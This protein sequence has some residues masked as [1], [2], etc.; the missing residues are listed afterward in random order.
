MLKHI[1]TKMLLFIIPVVIITVMT[2]YII[3]ITLGQNVINNEVSDKMIVLDR[4]KTTEIDKLINEM[5]SITVSLVATVSKTYDEIEFDEYETI[6]SSI[7]ETSPDV[8]GVAIVLEPYTLGDD[9]PYSATYAQLDDNGNIHS[10]TD[11]SEG[12]YSFYESEYYALSQESDQISFTKPYKDKSTGYSIMVSSMPINDE[13]GDY[14]GCVV[15]KVKLSDISLMLNEYT[16]DVNKL[17]IIDEDGRFI[18]HN[19]ISKVEDEISIYDL[20][21]QSLD[22]E[23]INDMFNDSKGT[24]DFYDETTHYRAYYSTIDRFNWKL[25]YVVEYETLQSNITSSTPFFILMAILTIFV[26]SALII[27]LMDKYIEKP[28]RVVLKELESVT[29]NSYSVDVTA[30]L[31]NR[32]DEFGVIGTELNNMKIRLKKYQSELEEA[33]NENLSFAEEMKVQNDALMKSEVELVDSL[34][35]RR[36]ILNALPDIIFLVNADGLVLEQIGYNTSTIIDTSNFVG[37]NLRDVL[38]DKDLCENIIEKSKITLKTSNVELLEICLINDKTEEYFDIRF[39]ECTTETVLVLIRNMTTFQKQL[40]DINYLTNFDQLTGLL[41]RVNLRKQMNELLKGKRLPFTI[42]VADINGIKLVNSSYGFEVGDVFIKTFSDI[43]LS[44]N[45]PGKIL[46]YY[47]GGQFC[48]VLENADEK[49]AEEFVKLVKEECKLHYVK[50]INITAAFGY[51]C[52]HDEYSS[53][54]YA[55]NSAE[56]FLL[57]NKHKEYA[58]NHINTVEIINRTLQAKSPR[59]Q[60][61]SDRVAELCV[62]FAVACGFSEKEQKEMHTAGLLHDIG[63]IGI[64]EDILDKPGKLDD[65]EFVEMRRHPEIGFKI[66]E[67]SGNMKEIASIIVSH[68]EKWDGTGYPYRLKGEDIPFKSRMITIIDA[69]DAMVSDRSYRKGMPQDVAVSELIKCKGTQFDPELV[70]IFIEKVL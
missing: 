31:L 50:D 65:N 51:Y 11:Y 45:Y 69:Y 7:M 34:S 37:N 20:E 25:I 49:N 32:S 28:I 18:A 21:Y 1:K 59:E 40:K 27:F 3:S 4:L 57:A 19:D 38:V 66:L 33:V 35:Y 29:D 9:V 10:N 64:R 63:K 17:Y 68:H 52:I 39:A 62:K 42:I 67:A 23:A 61:H 44:V 13:N 5:E 8:Y 56:K 46:G 30:D 15:T 2:S 54:D 36:A 24:F 43:L 47:G 12:E 16:N 41:N 55:V 53:I 48:I 70:D 6:L 58:N 26:L 22:D 60:F 14:I